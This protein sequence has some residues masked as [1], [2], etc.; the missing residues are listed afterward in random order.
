MSE[1]QVHLYF[2]NEREVIFQDRSF[3]SSFE[4]MSS[5]TISEK[6]DSIEVPIVGYEIMKERAKFTV[7]KLRVE[8][9]T[10]GDCWFICRRY[11]D[12]V[13]LHGKLKLD[14]PNARLPL[15]RKK[16]LGDN[17]NSNFLKER[18]EGLQ[19]FINI[20]LRNQE[21]Y[22]S[23]CVKDFLCLDEPPA[24]INSFEESKATVEALEEKIIQLTK[25]LKEKEIEHEKLKISHSMEIEAKLRLVSFVQESTKECPSCAIRLSQIG[26]N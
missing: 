18:L 24:Y 17:F 25:K 11:T 19:D 6:Q 8:N 16:W 3:E 12:F 14:Y 21:L 4:G 26:I 9:K 5:S 23:P 22:S 15:P 1:P 10:T 2:S 13:Q 7:Y 20:I